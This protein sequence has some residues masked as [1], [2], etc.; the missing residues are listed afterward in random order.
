MKHPSTRLI[1]EYWNRQRGERPAPTRSEID[2]AAI[3][4]ALGDTFMLAADFIDGIR[5]RL[6][7]TRVCALFGREIK[8]E[9]FN[10]LWSEASRAQ[11]AGIVDAVVNEAIGAVAGVA[12]RTEKGTE[13]ELEL[14]L[15]PIGHDERSR[16]RAIGA[17][18]PMAPPYWL[19]EEAVADLELQTLRHIGAEQSTTRVARFQRGVSQRLRHGFTVYSGGREIGPGNGTN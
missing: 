5:F 19:G 13:T 17:L 14:L 1:Y 8:G 11:V 4:H 18:V 2:P 7:G 6:A 10:A 15:L 12:G 16:V 9:G 3:R